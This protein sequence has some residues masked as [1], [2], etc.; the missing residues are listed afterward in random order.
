MKSPLIS[1]VIPAYN[2]SNLLKGTINSVIQQTYTK[3]EIIV[4]D[5]GSEIDLFPIIK[6]F[7]DNRIF[8]FKLE[9]KNANVARNF[10]VENSKGTYIAMLDSDDIWLKNHLKDCLLTINQI[11]SDGLYGSI[12]LRNSKKHE[13]TIIV[14]D[15]NEYKSIINYLLS[16]GYGAQ[17][18]T[19]FMTANSAKQIL[20]NPEL[21]RHQDYDFILRYS[22]KFILKPKIEPTVIYN[23]NSNI[24]HIDFKSCIK[25]IKEVKQNI[26]PDIY[27]K[28]NLH[29][30]NLAKQQGVSTDII[31]YYQRQIAL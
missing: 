19:L 15:L 5:D 30:L 4:V 29:M 6:E 21:N 14:K 12:I 26:A 18:S 10:G 25:F 13:T 31:L 2:N 11:K 28:Y 17:T 16:Y 1:I 24:K 20:W 27:K 3:F 7:D 23:I 22:H 9:H 8:Y